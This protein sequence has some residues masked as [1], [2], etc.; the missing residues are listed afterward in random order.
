ME[1]GPNAASFLDAAAK[2]LT[3]H[4]AA[5]AQPSSVIPAGNDVASFGEAMSLRV[6]E[7]GVY[8][9]GVG[10]DQSQAPR[11]TVNTFTL[12]VTISFASDLS[13]LVAPPAP[14]D[15]SYYF[16]YSLFG[17]DITTKPFRDLA[18]AAF[19]AQRASLRIRGGREE[20]NGLLKHI[21]SLKVHLC[22][23]DG[24][25]G[26]ATIALEGLA[27]AGDSTIDGSFPIIPVQTPSTGLPLVGVQVALRHE[28]SGS[29]RRPVNLKLRDLGRACALC[30]VWC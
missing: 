28:A 12:A 5:L 2:N 13:F 9:V 17:N 10:A 22:S 6:G 19:E 30:F 26:T 3:P 23:H 8:E 21:H 25:L 4:S 7:D 1:P 27:V 18:Q 24:L 16:Y 11:S 15:A 20:V 14:K 29:L